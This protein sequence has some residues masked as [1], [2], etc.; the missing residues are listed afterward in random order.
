MPSIS[1]ASASASE[2]TLVDKANAM[3][4]TDL[5]TR[6]FEEVGAE[7]PDIERDHA[8]IDAAC[9]WMVKNPEWF[10]VGGRAATCS[11]TSSPTSAR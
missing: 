9:M 8:Y 11:G 5:W 3:R 4:A 1:R 10:D 6:T 2:L 7:Y